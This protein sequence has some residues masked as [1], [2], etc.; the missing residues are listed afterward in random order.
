MDYVVIQL[1]LIHTLAVFLNLIH[2]V[3]VSSV[4]GGLD[5]P[6]RVQV[7]LPTT[8]VSR[9]LLSLLWVLLPLADNCT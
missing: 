9:A 6:R 2:K 1:I 3:G 8:S 7:L 5:S 4:V